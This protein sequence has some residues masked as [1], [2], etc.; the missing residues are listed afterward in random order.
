MKS[1][2]ELAI[3]IKKLQAT[4]RP[5]KEDWFSLLFDNL[6]TILASLKSPSQLDAWKKGMS[7]AAE[8]VESRD[9]SLPYGLLD[10]RDTILTARDNKKEI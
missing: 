4:E 8:A 9:K 7:D 1:A 2:K 5:D 3:A 10:I 6:D